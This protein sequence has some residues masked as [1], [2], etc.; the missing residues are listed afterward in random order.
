MRNKLESYQLTSKGDREQNQDCAMY[1]VSNEY[2]LFVVADGLGGHQGGEKASR[3]F[4]QGVFDQA[5]KHQKLIKNAKQNSEKIFSEWISAAVNDMKKY[6]KD[7]EEVENAYTTCVILY[8]DKNITAIAHCGDSR[9]YRMNKKE[10]LWRTKDHSLIQQRVDEGH[11]TESEMGEHPNQNLIT[12]TINALT[13][14][15]AEIAIYPPIEKGETFILCTDG[16]WEYIKKEDLLRLATT[17][18]GSSE[19]RRTAKMMNMHAYGSGDNLTV[20]WVRYT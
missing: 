8:L 4:C 3:F 13:D 15:Q 20:Q 9:I 10:V 7:D 14:H 5:A 1:K 6:F 11:I 16:F 18:D 17:S 19:L 12:R 2:G